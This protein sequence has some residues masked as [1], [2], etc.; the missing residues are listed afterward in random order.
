MGLKQEEWYIKM[1]NYQFTQFQDSSGYFLCVH[2][3]QQRGS[4]FHPLTFL[5]IRGLYLAQKNL[6]CNFSEN[7]MGECFIHIV[8]MRSHKVIRAASLNFNISVEKN[9]VEEKFR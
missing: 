9:A 4:N 6:W 8:M 2:Y 7:I 5:R 3:T 1:E